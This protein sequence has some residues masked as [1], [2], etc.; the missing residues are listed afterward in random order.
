MAALAAQPNLQAILLRLFAEGAA[1]DVLMMVFKQA[2]FPTQP[3]STISHD[4]TSS[5]YWTAS[6]NVEN[7]LL[8]P[9]LRMFSSYILPVFPRCRIYFSPVGGTFALDLGCFIRALE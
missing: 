3:T 9:R 7:L 6:S 5:L 8:M 1:E 2:V 4:I